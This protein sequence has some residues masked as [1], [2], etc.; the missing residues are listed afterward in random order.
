MVRF[1][2]EHGDRAQLTSWAACCGVG[3]PCI[4]A[5]GRWKASTSSED[6]RTSRAL[7]LDAQSMVA[8][9]IRE[10]RLLPDPL[11]EEL[12]LAR[13]STFMLAKET[14]PEVVETQLQRLR[15]FQPSTHAYVADHVVEK[16]EAVSEQILVQDPAEGL[17]Y[18]I[19][20]SSRAK[21]CRLHRR[22]GCWRRPGLGYQN[23]EEYGTLPAAHL[24]T[25]VCK[26][27]WK[28]GVAPVE[29]KGDEDGSSSGSSS[30]S[31]SSAPTERSAVVA[32]DQLLD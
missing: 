3:Q 12:L 18:F 13:M 21:V 20:I 19:V 2:S 10:K 11:G 29:D 31:S 23:F 4:D 17:D 8:R 9:I 16:L 15:F 6:I 22:G 5:L 28:D 14:T 30:E 27:C 26:Q 7:V 1:W 32:D 24:Y 25:A